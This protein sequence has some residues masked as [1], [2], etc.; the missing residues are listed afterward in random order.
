MSTSLEQTIHYKQIKNKN[1][2]NMSTSLEQTIHYKQISFK[3]KNVTKTCRPHLS[4]QFT[5]N[6]YPL[7][8]RM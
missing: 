4:K 3:N 7:R 2:T 8:I 5:I 6:K 1:V